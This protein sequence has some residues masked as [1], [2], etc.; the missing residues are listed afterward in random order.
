MQ[1]GFPTAYRLHDAALRHAKGEVD[2]ALPEQEL[3]ASH[4]TTDSV[5]QSP[6]AGNHANAISFF[7]G[8]DQGSPRG[9][10]VRRA[11]IMER[12]D[13]VTNSNVNLTAS[14]SPHSPAEEPEQIQRE[15]RARRF[16][17][18]T[19]DSNEAFAVEPFP[20]SPFVR[21]VLGNCDVSS[22][23]T[24]DQLQRNWET[25]R[26]TVSPSVFRKKSPAELLEFWESARRRATRFS[27]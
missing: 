8:N 7:A 10:V 13:S 2:A 11:D 1:L 27:I 12:N 21:R 6:R 16:S 20:T 15:A 9:S 4:D 22:P 14:H 18:V 26:S 17:S 3:E 5:S 23:L 24:R 19:Q 25:R